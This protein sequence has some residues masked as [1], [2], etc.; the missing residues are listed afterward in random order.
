MSTLHRKELYERVMQEA[1]LKSICEADDVLP[2]L[3]RDLKEL[4]EDA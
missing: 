3:P 1:G 4:W 2:Q